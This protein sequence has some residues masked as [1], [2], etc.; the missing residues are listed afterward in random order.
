[1]R[2]GLP[3]KLLPFGARAFCL[4]SPVPFAAWNLGGDPFTA[5]TASLLKPCPEPAK[6]NLAV[7]KLASFFLTGDD[8]SGRKVVQADGC[9]PAVDILPARAAR[10]EGLHLALGEQCFVCLGNPH[11]RPPRTKSIAG[12]FF[13]GDSLTNVP[14]KGTIVPIMGTKGSSLS[15]GTALLGRVRLTLLSLLL[16]QP[17]RSFYV[18]E[19]IRLADMGQGAVQR[20]LARL[21]RVGLLTRSTRGRQTFYQ[22]N[23][24]APIFA[25]L[26][27][28]IRKITGAAD[29]LRAALAPLSVSIEKAFI[30]GSVARG[31][32]LASSD[33]D[34][35]V[36]GDVSFLDVVSAVSP[37]QE[38]LGR[39]IN[40]TVFPSEEYQQ[41]LAVGD[42]FL[43]QVQAGD[44]LFLIGGEDESR[45][46]E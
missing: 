14:I 4:E 28:L 44:I 46:L 10:P 9:L 5:R 6:S 39:E 8:N 38:V 15:L 45:S 37:L 24:S 42:H 1:M 3:A 25:E 17:D 27:A 18:R 16:S 43:T 36:V 22:A 19:I 30:Y 21:H 23:S 29:L 7:S 33:I 13:H 31:E 11:H 40:P 20:E 2:I 34:L 26:R 35:M 41:R 32:E 12:A